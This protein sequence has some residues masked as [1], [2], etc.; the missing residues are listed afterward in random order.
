MD[1]LK[2]AF[3]EAMDTQAHMQAD[4]ENLSRQINKMAEVNSEL[5]MELENI[6]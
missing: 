2:L 1:Q 4:T 3:T 6:N 5:T